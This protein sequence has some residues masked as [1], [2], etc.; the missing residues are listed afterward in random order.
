[1]T[2]ADTPLVVTSRRVADATLRGDDFTYSVIDP[3]PSE[4]RGERRL[5]T[6][7][8]DGLVTEQRGRPVVDCRIRD[9]SRT[10]ARIQLDKDRPL[11]KTFL[12]GDMASRERFWAILVWQVGRDAGVRLTPL[13]ER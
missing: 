6:R 2:R 1:M 7:L 4:R 5:R 13:A 9:R 8:R 3:G 10:G 12:L 11:P